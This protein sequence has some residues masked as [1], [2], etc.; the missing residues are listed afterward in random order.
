MTTLR[1]A[2]RTAVQHWEGRPG[3]ATMSAGASRCVAIL[4]A[5]CISGGSTDAR[6]L[7]SPDAVELLASLR[8]AGL[9]PRSVA[10]YYRTF[11]RMLALS[12]ILTTSWPASPT[13]P[14][15]TRDAISPGDLDKL[16]RWLRGMGYADT[17]DLAI[18]MRGTGL[19]V[20]VE[21]LTEVNLTLTR[22]PEGANYDVLHVVGKGAHE[23][24]LPVVRE[25]T[26][27]LLQDGVRMAAMRARSYRA[28]LDR[29]TKGVKACGIT[30]RLATPHSV[31]H[32]YAAEVL[33]KS[34]GNVALVRDLLGH[35]SIATTSGYLS[36]D[37][38]D[39]AGV[40]SA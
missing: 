23:R 10:S 25:D 7:S 30:S 12:D 11:R 15:K 36:V 4:D 2:L 18:L 26:R 31:R 5:K 39:M 22:G 24:L 34:G 28:H 1:D 6:S 27:T 16:L 37:L 8:E 38:E 17:V 21:A 13:P 29:W 3:T 19:R 14:R 33:K 20:N 40:L 9:A 32:G 35:A